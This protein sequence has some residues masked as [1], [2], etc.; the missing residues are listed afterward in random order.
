M[1][2]ESRVNVTAKTV[3]KFEKRRMITRRKNSRKYMLG[4]LL[5]GNSRAPLCSTRSQVTRMGK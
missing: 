4:L 5:D 1:L 3:S 2:Y